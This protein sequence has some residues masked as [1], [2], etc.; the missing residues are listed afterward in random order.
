M[1]ALDVRFD[2]AVGH[3]E[4]PNSYKVTLLL[5]VNKL[6]RGSYLDY[7]QDDVAATN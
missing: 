4:V 2:L 1:T 7:L 6:D 3:F 5:R